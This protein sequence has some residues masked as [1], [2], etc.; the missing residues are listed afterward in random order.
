MRK[1]ALYMR[2]STDDQSTEN[3]TPDLERMALARGCEIVGRFEEKMSGAKKS[4]PALDALMQ[5]ARRGEYAV[6]FV[7]ALDRLGRNQMAIMEMVLELD[8][9]G[10]QVVSHQETWLDTQGM[11]RP[12]L[13]SIFA[14]MAEQERARLI[15][16]T[17]AGLAV[18]RAAG[19]T[20][21]RPKAH[22]DI[23]Q[24]LRLRKAGLSMADA[25]KRLG[26]GVATLHRHLQSPDVPASARARAV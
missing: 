24:A 1:A 4:R 17:M 13:L 20:L 18:A 6:I 15:E 25:A 3:Q 7:W 19:K 8:R 9:I 14:W 26:V 22:L 11:A 2:V 23:D 10:C 16:R 21:G 5:G 12:L